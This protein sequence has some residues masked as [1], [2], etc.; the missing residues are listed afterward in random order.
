V[1]PRSAV[2]RQSSGDFLWVKSSTGYDKRPVKLGPISDTEA[3]ILSG[4]SSGDII[5]SA[6]TP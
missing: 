4:V 6:P 1:V 2:G 3:V 5:R